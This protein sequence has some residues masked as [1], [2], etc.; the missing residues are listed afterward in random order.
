MPC[1]TVRCRK[2]ARAA[3][4]AV[5]RNRLA[6]PYVTTT[7]NSQGMSYVSASHR[8]YIFNRAGLTMASP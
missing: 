2:T 8:L 3:V 7:L 6:Q 1:P 4:G 5:T